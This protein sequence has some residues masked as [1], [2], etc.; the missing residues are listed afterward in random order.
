MTLTWLVEG[1]SSY[2]CSNGVSAFEEVKSFGSFWSRS[3]IGDK[4]WESSK[5]TGQSIA[6]H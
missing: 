1:H 5:Q 4:K 3:V 6:H 2:G